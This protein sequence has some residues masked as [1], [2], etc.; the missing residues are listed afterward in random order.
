MLAE[1]CIG[2]SSRRILHNWVT[3][4]HVGS[5]RKLVPASDYE[6]LRVTKLERMWKRILSGFTF[7]GMPHITGL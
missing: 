5:T 7:I 1:I 2:P 6:S 3:R 4:N